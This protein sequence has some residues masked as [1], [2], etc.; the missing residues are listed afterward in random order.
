[1]R[2]HGTAIIAKKALIDESTFIGPYCVIGS[3]VKIGKNVTLHSHVNI[4]GDTLI[5]DG[6]QIFPFSSIGT[7]PQ[8]LKYRGE[9]SRVIIGKNNIIREYST[10]NTGTRL[11]SMETII[12]DDCL[13]MTSAHVAHDCIVGNNVIMANNATLG[14]HVNV[15]ND[16]I[17]GGLSAV[18]QHIKIGCH[19]I[20]GGMS[21]VVNNVPPF[22]SISGERAQI[23]GVNLIGMKRKNFAREVIQEIQELYESVFFNRSNELFA[24]KISAAKKRFSSLA[25]TYVFDF[26]ETVEN[27]GFCQSAKNKL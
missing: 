20:I 5:G 19:A 10:I 8:D 16:V 2:I 4:D 25:S 26:V 22:A 21:T 18:H 23:I 14:G 11:G 13:L 17:I 6:C 3:Q 24:C 7:I 12:G 15:E 9:N 27:R 1:M